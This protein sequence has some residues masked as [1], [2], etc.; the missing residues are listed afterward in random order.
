MSKRTNGL[1][2]WLS[3]MGTVLAMIVSWAKHT[4]IIWAILHGLCGWFYVIYYAIVY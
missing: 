4:S 3:A 2:D 1:L